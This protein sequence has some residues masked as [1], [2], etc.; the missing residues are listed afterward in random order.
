MTTTK[1]LKT[2]TDLAYSDKER[3]VVYNGVVALDLTP[4]EALRCVRDVRAEAI[5]NG[6][7]IQAQI[8]ELKGQLNHYTRA[9]TR[10]D[11]IAHD[12]LSEQREIYGPHTETGLYKV[13][14]NDGTS[15][16]LVV[17]PSESVTVDAS[18]VDELPDELCKITRTPRLDVIKGQLKIGWA[19]P[20]VELVVKKFGTEPPAAED[21]RWK[22]T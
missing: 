1:T 18:V 12:I 19:H 22:T 16:S 10:C 11:E 6:I 13:D 7:S 14:L 9:E 15:V 5:R 4:V 21:V 2:I 20:G 3:A 8:N 17:T